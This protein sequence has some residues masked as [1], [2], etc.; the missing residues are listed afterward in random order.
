MRLIPVIVSLNR[1]Q[2]MKRILIIAILATAIP[3][4]A[5]AQTNDNKAAPS[6]KAEQEVVQVSKEIVEAYG[7]NDFAALDR[8]LADDYISTQAF[9]IQSKAQLMDAWKSGR[10]KY[11]S[12]SDTD[13]SVKVYGDSAVTTGI[14]TLKGRNP[15]REFTIHARYTGAWVK[16]KGQWRLVASQLSEVAGQLTAEINK[17]NESTQMFVNAALAK[18]WAAA[19]VMYT[20]DAVSYPPHDRAVKGR[21]AIQAWLEKFP[22]ITAFKATNVKVE[23]RGDLAYVLGTYT[24]TIAP[25]GASGP[26]NDTGKYVEI[27]RKQPDGSWLIAVDIF[28]SDLPADTANAD[29]AAI[30]KQSRAHH[31][32]FARKD[33]DGVLAV[34]SADVVMMPPNEP[35]IRGKQALRSWFAK[36]FSQDA[37]KPL[38]GASDGLELAGDMAVERLLLRDSTGQAIGKAIHVYRR[39]ADGDWKITQDIWSTDVPA[40]SMKGDKHVN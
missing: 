24:M 12:A 18:N 22:P 21:A 37:F 15:A 7:R 16:Q 28:N 14:L 9:G 40:T 10:I 36:L 2:T 31:G 38:S 26:V 29:H 1:R 4:L 17:I 8:L 5:L 6:G 19:A 25:P 3:S 33:V 30:A 20:D 34:Y 39:Q 13:L 27:R 11:S 23:V 32:A 35:V